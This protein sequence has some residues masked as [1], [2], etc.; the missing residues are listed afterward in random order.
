MEA[1]DPTEPEW[2]YPTSPER[3]I[4]PTTLTL[5][6][7]NTKY[8]AYTVLVITMDGIVHT[9]EEDG[10]NTNFPCLSFF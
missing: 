2:V 9:V 8:K 6:L 1:M 5:E 7:G 10:V 3:T 4:A